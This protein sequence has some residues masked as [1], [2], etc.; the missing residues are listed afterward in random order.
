MTQTPQ[1]PSHPPLYPLDPR[2]HA[3]D[4]WRPAPPAQQCRRRASAPGWASLLGSVKKHRTKRSKHRCSHAKG[5][6]NGLFQH[7]E[8]HPRPKICRQATFGAEV[9]ILLRHRLESLKDQKTSAVGFSLPLF[10]A[11]LLLPAEE[12]DDFSV[13]KWDPF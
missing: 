9:Q 10:F 5:M 7:L 1:F 2:P 4:S 13:V 8:G 11:F 12:R 6:E 3:T